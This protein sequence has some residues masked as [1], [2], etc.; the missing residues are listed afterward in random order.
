GY[1]L[2][3]VRDT[4][5]LFTSSDGV[6]ID[7]NLFTRTSLTMGNC[8]AVAVHVFGPTVSHNEFTRC[9]WEGIDFRGSVNMTAE[10]NVFNGVC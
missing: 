5:L 8:G 2:D 4:N 6:L 7:N 1:D 3:Q 9:Y 10:Y